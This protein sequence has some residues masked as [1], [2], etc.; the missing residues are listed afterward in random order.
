MVGYSG[1]VNELI[2]VPDVFSRQLPVIR[3]YTGGG[4]VVTDSDTI[5]VT[6]IL[7]VSVISI[8]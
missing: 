3:R 4:T 6:L 8:I 2:N 5:F 1:K 7:N